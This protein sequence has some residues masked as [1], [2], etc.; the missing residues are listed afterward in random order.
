MPINSQRWF[1]R[2]EDYT[3]RQAQPDS[4]QLLA[5][6]N[7][8]GPSLHGLFKT[9]PYL[10]P[11]PLMRSPYDIKLFSWIQMYCASIQRHSLLSNFIVD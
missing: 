3:P 8:S 11:L 1:Q 2:K 9:R 10:I 6:F 7:G 5:G 4:R